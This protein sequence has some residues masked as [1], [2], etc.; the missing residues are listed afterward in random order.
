M[1]QALKDFNYKD[2]SIGDKI[3]GITYRWATINDLD[4]IVK[5]V[6]DAEESF[7]EYYKNKQLYEMDSKTRVL[8]AVKEY[9]VAG[10]LMVSRETEG[11]NIGSI[12]CTSTAHTHRN[13][14]IATNMILIGTKYLKDSGLKK[15]FL[16]YTYT[17]L[18]KFY[19]RAGYKICMEYY[20]GEKFSS[21]P[22]SYAK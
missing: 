9:E 10:A 8:I 17:S 18:V 1:S 20:M 14:G 11:K 21:T 5:T 16:G 22:S 13:Q 4:N 3:N 2:N 19:S 6:S 12:G 7:A 15:A